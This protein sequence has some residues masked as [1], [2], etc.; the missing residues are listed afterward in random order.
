[1]VGGMSNDLF[2]VSESQAGIRLDK[3]VAQIPSVASRNRAQKAIQSGKVHLNGQ[4]VDPEQLGVKLNSGDVVSVEWNRPGTS[5]DWVKGRL[6]LQQ[7]N[8]SILFEDDDLL[9]INKPPGL[10][11]DSATR[12]QQRTRD[13]LKKRLK[14][15]LKAQGKHP[16]IVHRI[17][18]DT[19]GVV[20]VAKTESSSEAL[21]HQFRTHT[22]VRKY[23]L[24]VHGVLRAQGEEW[25]NPMMWD[26]A[27]RI[28]R[29]V[30]PEHEAAFHARCWATVTQSYRS[31]SVLEVKLDSGRRNQIRLQA[32]LR[33]HPLIGERLYIPAKWA[34]TLSFDRQALHAHFLTV[35]HPSTGQEITFKAPLPTDLRALL[36]R[37]R[38]SKTK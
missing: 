11:T 36:E 26:R 27:Q 33:G 13:T 10:L 7:A 32:Q 20:L 35:Q 4:A 24:A 21:R 14:V 1:M 9:A 3:A 16:F 23:W 6:Q 30:E 19:S 25:I 12:H 5:K 17:D 29:P 22:P 31:A 2:T 8:L 37:I 38:P 18:R 15:Y 28:Q 34:P